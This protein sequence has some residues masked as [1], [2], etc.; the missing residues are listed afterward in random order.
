MA[1]GDE[2]RYAA[3]AAADIEHVVVRLEV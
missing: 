1:L 2:A 3:D